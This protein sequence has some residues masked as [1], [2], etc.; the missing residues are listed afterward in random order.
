MPPHKKYV[1]FRESA[2]FARAPK[3]GTS[4]KPRDYVTL[5][6]P[7]CVQPFSEIL[8]SR[9]DNGKAE[10]CLKHLRTCAAAKDAGIVVPPP[11]KRARV[12]DEPLGTE[13]PRDE[14]QA[15]SAKPVVGTAVSAGDS[16]VIATLQTNHAEQMAA[17]RAQHQELMCALTGRLE[18]KTNQ[19]TATFA[20]GG[21]SPP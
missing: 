19:L 20:N 1:D 12:V 8:V 17:Q 7:H 4:S 18:R 9:L 2:H 6:C 3:Q 5:T 21:L 15:A 16:A 11:G 14:L 10:E 13:T